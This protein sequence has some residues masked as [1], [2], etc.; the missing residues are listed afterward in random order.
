[1]YHS[2]LGLKVI[3]KKRE[4]GVRAPPDQRPELLYI[5][6]LFSKFLSV[7]WSCGWPDDTECVH[8]QISVPTTGCHAAVFL[9]HVEGWSGG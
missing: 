2:T 1:M 7:W 9:V 8:H 6:L 5:E 4:E 3:E